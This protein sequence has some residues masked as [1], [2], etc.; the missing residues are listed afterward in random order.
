MLQ[1]RDVGTL[2]APLPA[3]NAGC[4]DPSHESSVSY[5]QREVEPT[6]M[7]MLP[8]NSEDEHEEILSPSQ[9]K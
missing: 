3:C 4:L 1:E 8:A 5:W 9:V 6:S 2:E 7:T